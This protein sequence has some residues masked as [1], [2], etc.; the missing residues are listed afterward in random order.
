MSTEGLLPCFLL[1]S[2]RCRSWTF[3][4]NRLS[5]ACASTGGTEG[6]APPSTQGSRC[7]SGVCCGCSGFGWGYRPFIEFQEMSWSLLL[8]QKLEA[9]TDTV[10]TGEDQ[11]QGLPCRSEGPGWKRSRAVGG[12]TGFSLW[13]PKPWVRERAKQSQR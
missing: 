7:C 12:K 6:G 3:A 5:V 1:L 2:C 8:T 11:S 10:S 9:K 13:G 4:I